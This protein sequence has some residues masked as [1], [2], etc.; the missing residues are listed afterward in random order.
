MSLRLI[1]PAGDDLPPVLAYVDLT[2]GTFGRGRNLEPLR[3][4]LPKDFQLA[5]NTPLLVAFQLE[6]VERAAA[7]VGQ[8]VEQP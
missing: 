3:L 2:K 6:E 1:G 7:A 5:D 4:Q 8:P